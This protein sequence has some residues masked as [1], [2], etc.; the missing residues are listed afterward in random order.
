MLYQLC[1]EIPEFP[2]HGGRVE[3]MG[4][5]AGVC[6]SNEY[7]HKATLNDTIIALFT[8]SILT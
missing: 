5:V 7:D 4:V 1:R 8:G 6:S 2:G 3:E